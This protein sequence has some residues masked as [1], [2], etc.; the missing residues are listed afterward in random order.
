MQIPV[1]R[2]II[3][4]RILVNYRVDP[5][6]LEKFLPRPFRPKLIDG[7]GMALPRKAPGSSRPRRVAAG[8]PV[9]R[10]PTSARP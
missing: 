3:D 10:S 8:V 2:G 1:I 7:A 6:V 4:R 9:R 5:E